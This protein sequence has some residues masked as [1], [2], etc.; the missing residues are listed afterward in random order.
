[1][2][3]RYCGA[4]RSLLLVLLLGLPVATARAQHRFTDSDLPALRRLIDATV[5]GNRLSHAKFKG[6]QAAGSAGLEQ[7]S[8]MAK[9]W[10]ADRTDPLTWYRSIMPQLKVPPTVTYD[11]VCSRERSVILMGMVGRPPVAVFS[12]GE[13]TELME[14]VR[15][16]D[17]S[18]L[19]AGIASALSKPGGMANMM[20]QVLGKTPAMEAALAKVEAFYRGSPGLEV[21]RDTAGVELAVQSTRASGDSLLIVVI[22]RTAFFADFLPNCE[23]TLPAGLVMVV[24][25]KPREVDVDAPFRAAEREVKRTGKDAGALMGSVYDACR[26]AQPDGYE[27]LQRALKE[28]RAEQNAELQ[29]RKANV[30]WYRRHEAELGPRMRAI[31]AAFEGD[32]PCG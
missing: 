12:L 26:D 16:G 13:G 10:E 8:A 25:I 21:A 28:P 4:K 31:S 27:W 19:D 14:K 23:E 7:R 20:S 6:E 11:R 2:R 32:D 24:T 30:A 3:P 17:Q 22:P 1:M 5:E 18:G 15:K 29:A 9:Q